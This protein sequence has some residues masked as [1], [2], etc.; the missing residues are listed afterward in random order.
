MPNYL[1][2]YPH[3]NLFAPE[4]SRPP[5][6]GC[7]FLDL[8]YSRVRCFKTSSLFLS[9]ALALSSDRGQPQVLIDALQPHHSLNHLQSRSLVRKLVAGF[10]A[11]GL[12][13]GDT[14]CLHLFNSI[15]YS[16]FVLAIIGAGGVV[17]GT[18]PTSTA[19]E[20][21]HQF[22]TGQAKYAIT[23]TGGEG[24]SVLR[25]VEK[26]ARTSGIP[27]K[28]IF[29]FDHDDCQG[30]LKL[31]VGWK[32]WRDL[33]TYGERDWERFDD[34]ELSRTTH[35]GLFFSSGTTG[36]PKAIM[37]SHLNII[38]QHT[39]VYSA[40]PRDYEIS[41]IIAL[42]I[43]HVA[44]GM[45]VNFSGLKDGQVHYI[46]KRFDTE[47]FF[48]AHKINRV[49]EGMM[50]PPMVV[51][52]IKT[53]FIDK[54]DSLKSLKRVICGAAP[55]KKEIQAQ[56]QALLPSDA[57]VTQSLGMTELSCMGLMFPP[58]E[59]DDTGSCGRLIPNLEA[60]YVHSSYY[61]NADSLIACINPS[62]IMDTSGEPIITPNT[63]GEICYRGP[64]VTLGYFQNPDENTR[65][66][67]SDG[68]VRSGDI[69]YCTSP[70]THSEVADLNPNTDPNSNGLWYIVDRAR[71]MIKVRAFQVA[72][73]EIEAVLLCHPDIEDAA[74]VGYPG[75]DETGELVMAFVVRRQKP[76]DQG[77][78]RIPGPIISEE[79]VHE[80]IK[81]RLTRYK[82]LTGG[83]RFVDSIPKTASGKILRKV[84]KNG[85]TRDRIDAVD[86]S[87]ELSR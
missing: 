63:A 74:V 82:W 47:S 18:S 71:E 20:L 86:S 61:R 68:F 85:E 6:K 28:N 44:V 4:A 16:I 36:S 14:V 70:P 80:W 13:A 38:A 73:A 23:E 10:H 69:G 5:N 52:I 9:G 30:D 7:L 48:K 26:T 56:L 42:P 64:T 79:E 19:V 50:V 35:A 33:L 45:T 8:R 1:R 34:M 43:F 55:M 65:I 27:R 11:T 46:F 17:L 24:E 87:R 21:E 59:S 3:V 15:L 76:K 66:F 72:P 75:S 49:T 83:V 22:T 62:R 29:V 51:A 60:K 67:T 39:S 54:R 84:L 37:L 25:L 53:P 31:P 78:R 32:S 2:Y 41:R 58:G 81:Q 57:Q 12:Q 77:E 40:H